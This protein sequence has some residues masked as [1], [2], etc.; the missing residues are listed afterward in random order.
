MT[1][2]DDTYGALLVGLTISAALWGITNLQVL[3][4]SRSYPRDL[5]LHKLAVVELWLLDAFHLALVAHGVYHYLITN[6]R[7]IV[8][9]IIWS[10]KLEIAIGCIA[11]ISVQSLYIFQI[12]R[13]CDVL[14]NE[15]RRVQWILVVL[16][17]LTYAATVNGFF[18]KELLDKGHCYDFRQKR[19][20]HSVRNP[21]FLRKVL[22]VFTPIFIC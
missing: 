13:I 9:D 15:T 7:T 14:S 16:L 1:F 6:R 19:I 8:L 12:W 18:E 10:L 11:I 22:P 3:T 5:I 21:A 4:Y 20:A 17:L 2:Y